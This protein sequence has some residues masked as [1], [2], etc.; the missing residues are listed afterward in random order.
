VHR[1]DGF[2]K[3]RQYL[4]NVTAKTVAWYRDSFRSFER[5]HSSDAYPKQSLTAFVTA[6]RDTGVSPISCNT[7]CRP[8]QHF[9]EESVEF[10][11][12]DNVRCFIA[13][14]SHFH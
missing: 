9:T 14:R 2:V 12:G 3:S 8:G 7:Y 4:K 5:F 11:Q 6:L 1:F 13:L 10:C